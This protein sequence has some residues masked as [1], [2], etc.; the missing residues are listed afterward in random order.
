MKEDAIERDDF[1]PELPEDARAAEEEEG[2]TT[3]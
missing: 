2:M 1:A 3:L